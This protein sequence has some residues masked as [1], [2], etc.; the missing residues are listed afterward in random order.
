MIRMTRKTIFILLAA[1]TAFSAGGI[2]LTQS[3]G[4]RVDGTWLYRF[5]FDNYH[6]GCASFVEPGQIRIKGGRILGDLPFL[7]TD[8]FRLEGRVDDTVTGVWEYDGIVF[9]LYLDL[10]FADDTASG[11]WSLPD[12]GCKGPIRL[13]RGKL[14]AESSDAS[15]E[16]RLEE[17]RTLLDRGLITED[18]AAIKR[19]EIL[20]RL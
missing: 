6:A 5:G 16:E 14:P 9:T 13:A 19:R 3:A 8:D 2:A 17:L 1:I 18:E 10:K 20:D 12:L 7:L 11:R 4:E 15:A